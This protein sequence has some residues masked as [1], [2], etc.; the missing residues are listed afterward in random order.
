[1]AHDIIDNRSLLLIDSLR[2]ILPGS[3][4]AK[5]AVGYFFLSGLEAV[6]DSLENVNELYLLIGNTS[7]QATIEQIAE[8]Y[9]RLEQA[10]NRIDAQLYPK[11]AE[12]HQR[13]TESTSKIGRTVAAMDQTDQAEKLVNVLVR[14]VAEKRL[15]VRIYTKGRLHAKAYIFDYAP[16]YGETGKPVSRHENGLAIIGSSNLTISGL[17]HNTELNVIVHGNDNHEELTKW[18]NRIWDE[19]ED[20]EK[21]LTDELEQ[22]WPMVQVTPYEIYLKT[23]Y[24][25][26]KD[27]LDDE[28]AREFLW[29]IEI[30]VALADFQKNAVRRSV[31]IVRQYG[32]AFISDVVG[33]GKSYIG[34][35]V[36]KH[37]ERHDRT[38][39]LIICPATLVNMWEH[40]NEAYQLNAR[41]VSMGLLRE[42]KDSPSFNILLDNE[43]YNDRDFVLIDESHNFRKSDTQRY[44][45]LQ[46]YLHSGDRRCVLLTA[47]PRNRDLW[48]IYNQ[49]RL[50]HLDDRTLLPIDPPN[51]RKYFKSCEVNQRSLSTLLS[52]IMVRRTRVDVVRWYGFDSD[53]HERID[54][55]DF[56]Q[57][58]KC[59][60]QAYVEV[61]GKPQFFPKRHLQTIQYN[62]S[63]TYSG[64]YDKLLE[65]IGRPGGAAG[66]SEEQLNYSRY[67]LWNYVRKDKK[68]KPPYSELHRAGVNLRGLMRISLFK[69]FES[70]VEAFRITVQRLITSHRAFLT[71]MDD[72]IIPAGEAAADI[73]NKADVYEERELVDIL[74]AV[75]GKYK[76]EDF[77]AGRLREDIKHDLDILEKIFSIVAPITPDQ[78]DKIITLQNWL[79]SPNKNGL[80]LAE[81]KCL[82]FTQYADTAKYLYENISTTNS[83]SIEV[84]YGTDKDKSLV[85]GRFA[86][87]SNPQHLPKTAFSEIHIL[88][89]TDVMSEGLNLQ[90]AD[91]IINYD[92]HWNPLRL[93]QRFG[94]IDR[95][96]TE[97][98]NVYGYNFLPETEL[99]KG[100]GLKDRLLRRIQEI[101]DTLGEDAAILDPSE[102]LNQE[103]FIAIYRGETVDQYEDTDDEELV[104]LTEAEEFI[105][106]LSE[107]NPQLFEKISTLRDGIRAAKRN[108]HEG[109]V[110]LC[111][112]S[113]YRQLYLVDDDGEIISRDI[114]HILGVIKCDPDTPNVSIDNHH[115]RIVQSVREDFSKEVQARSAEQ[116]HA[117]SLT[118]AQRYLLRELRKLYNQTEDSY[119]KGQIELLEKAFRQPLTQAVRQEINAMHK[120]KVE[121][122]A[123]FDVLNKIN[124]RHELQKVT[125]RQRRLSEE[126]TVP[127][128]ICSM[129]IKS[130]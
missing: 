2:E 97:H 7:N 128:V 110:V 113:N 93:I 89:A 72:G 51:L 27:R 73:L 66:E 79:N 77:Y 16:V 14:L 24:E 13:L 83:A 45:I 122:L 109:T 48:D 62:I 11:R 38:R 88:I 26:V 111:R 35:A 82:I 94:R 31:Q 57:Y 87:K 92:L 123:L 22:S 125:D 9:Q 129:G 42:D 114:P 56:D 80:S 21:R 106:Q 63:A 60:R 23:L 17:T 25:L 104:D 28:T 67:G 100:L 12:I 43:R 1:M 55:F 78:D 84:I 64:L 4:V 81:K 91:Q 39:S 68:N 121:G 8:G 74:S 15:K 75:S 85:A 69:R 98:S 50:F 61:A 32:G 115:N 34:A 76:I 86:P 30:T 5:F 96:G 49:I 103:A 36:L 46:E 116:K 120:S 126:D 119:L 102:R 58:R 70:S 53:S 10:N 52:N 107:T 18:F 99:D 90:D 71:A 20:F 127:L 65:H 124:F 118:R 59:E 117:I 95:I 19:A 41:V 130:G 108:D 105:R 6:V 3:E 47:T 112:A 54:P 101:H 29:Q 37:F 40:Y 44:K 33:L